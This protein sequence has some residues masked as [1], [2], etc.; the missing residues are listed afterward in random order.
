[1]NTGISISQECIKECV[2]SEDEIVEIATGYFGQNY[3][4]EQKG[5]LRYKNLHE[6]ITNN[7][8]LLFF[9]SNIDSE[10]I[11]Q[12]LKKRKNVLV[13]DITTYPI[14]TIKGFLRI[15]LE[16][17]VVFATSNYWEHLPANNYF[18]NMV[19]QPRFMELNIH[20]SKKSH[21]YTLRKHIFNGV[22]YILSMANCTCLRNTVDV[23]PDHNGKP[24]LVNI[25]LNFE[26]G[27]SSNLFILLN[28]LT[29]KAQLNLYS[30]NVIIQAD[31]LLNKLKVDENDIEGNEIIFDG[32]EILTEYVNKLTVEINNKSYKN[33]FRLEN[34]VLLTDIIEEK[35]NR[36]L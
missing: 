34:S 12:S 16:S 17:E 25:I 28:K 15:A 19:I 24:Y 7:D 2:I 20:L 26:N 9:G 21:T 29:E 27:T 1:M 36:F 6:F 14:E 18:K 10:V 31:L 35:I 22:D 4:L 8:S 32:G 30:S 23:V 11:E 5:L 13:N 33:S 3:L